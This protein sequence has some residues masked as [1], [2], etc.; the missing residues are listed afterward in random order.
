MCECTD[1]VGGPLDTEFDIGVSKGH[2]VVGHN[3][4]LFNRPWLDDIM[5]QSNWQVKPPRADHVVHEDEVLIWEE[6]EVLG[7]PSLPC[8]SA[9]EHSLYIC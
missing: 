5:Y 2:E 3:Y 1:N 8:D 9:S 6:P 4:N 7:V